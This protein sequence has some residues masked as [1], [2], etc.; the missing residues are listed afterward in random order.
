MTKSSLSPLKQSQ[1][2]Q[3]NLKE[4]LS[5]KDNTINELQFKLKQQAVE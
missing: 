1:D 3:R 5:E 2:V 4:A